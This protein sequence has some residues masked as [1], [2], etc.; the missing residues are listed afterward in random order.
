MS[1]IER[2]HIVNTGK[3]KSSNARGY[4]WKYRLITKK[5]DRWY[6]GVE[7]LLFG[8][9]I[10]GGSLGAIT[11]VTRTVNGIESPYTY[12]AHYEQNS[13]IIGEWKTKHEL[14][15]VYIAS[16]RK[17][18]QKLPNYYDTSIENLRYLLKSEYYSSRHTLLAKIITDLTKGL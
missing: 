11:E 1:N 10:D 9:N 7:E 13:K 6:I 17:L 2:I 5:S 14:C 18:K 8:K 12:V 15:N 16:R 4:V 3:R